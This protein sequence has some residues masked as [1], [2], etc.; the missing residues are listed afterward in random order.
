MVTGVKK[1]SPWASSARNLSGGLKTI[2]FLHWN[3]LNQYSLLYFI[4]ASSKRDQTLG[5]SFS[6]EGWELSG[7][8]RTGGLE[9]CLW[10][11]FVLNM[12][13]APITM[14][15][16]ACPWVLGMH[17]SEETFKYL[18]WNRGHTVSASCSASLQGS[19]E[20]A[21]SKCRVHSKRSYFQGSED[22][23]GE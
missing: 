4:G 8:S 6:W 9:L 3:R 11:L 2:C 21:G 19:G 15:K 10:M 16:A 7:W 1:K 23:N 17:L 14:P 18:S 12:L 13:W 22:L 5:Q 20:H